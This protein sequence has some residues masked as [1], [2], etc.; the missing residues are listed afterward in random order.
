M[1]AQD[2]L[3]ALVF[4]GRVFFGGC[5]PRYPRE[6]LADGTGKLPARVS[7]EEEVPVPSFVDAGK[8]PAFQDAIQ[9]AT[10]LLGAEPQSLLPPL[11]EEEV[12]G[13]VSF[14]VPHEKID[15]I[16]TDLHEQFLEMGFYFF[17]YDN[18]Y[19]FNG[20]PDAVAMLPTTD[21]YAVVA[22]M[23]TSGNDFYV[24]NSGVI[25]WLKELEQEQPFVLSGIGYDYLEGIFTTSIKDPGALAERMYQ[26]CPDIVEQ[27]TDTVDELAQILQSGCLYFWWD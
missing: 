21:K 13:G 15:P 5:A 23:M 17:R 4:V 2:L 10:A 12:L 11:E 7:A 6:W 27:G 20:K 14:K 19:G 9:E 3:N 24:P 18:G 25:A 22:L 16:L 1:G 26:F 8:N